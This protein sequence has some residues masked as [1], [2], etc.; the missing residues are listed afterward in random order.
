M[1]LARIKELMEEQSLNQYKLAKLSGLS[2]S[3]LSNM[4]NKT[5]CPTIPT[6]EKICAGLSISMSEFFS[7]GYKAEALSVEQ[8]QLLKT[9]DNFSDREKKA[10]LLL[11]TEKE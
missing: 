8:K 7:D 5:T 2:L 11:F 1:L 9:W 3:T 4:F 10:F 6:L